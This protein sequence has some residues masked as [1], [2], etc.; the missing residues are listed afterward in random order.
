[1]SVA[2]DCHSGALFVAIAISGTHLP[3]C[4]SLPL[5]AIELALHFLELSFSS[6]KI[7]SDRFVCFLVVSP[8]TAHGMMPSAPI[9]DTP[10]MKGFCTC[11]LV[12]PG[13]E[14][15]KV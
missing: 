10:E 12:S 13:S 14:V 8:I 6:F 4:R 2:C 3:F 5:S 1:M 9:A 15:T 7:S 11:P